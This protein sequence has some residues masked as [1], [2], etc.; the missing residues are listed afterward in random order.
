MEQTESVCCAFNLTEIY[1]GRLREMRAIINESHR[2]WMDRYRQRSSG[3]QYVAARPAL[4][5]IQVDVMEA[6]TFCHIVSDVER[7][8]RAMNTHLDQV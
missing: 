3:A 4:H 5:I 2:N 6:D 1:R 8:L 7:R